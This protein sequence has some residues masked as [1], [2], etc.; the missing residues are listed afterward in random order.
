MRSADVIVVGAGPAGIAAAQAAAECGASVVLLDE[1]ARAGGQYFKRAAPSFALGPSDLSREHARGEQR[2]RAL[3]NPAITHIAEAIC[4]GIFDGGTVMVWHDGESKVFDAA[5]I[6]LATGAHDRPVPFPGWTLPGVMT[7][8][9][10]QSLAKTQWVMPG[11][12]VVL[13]G[14][15][16]FLLPVAQQ[17]IRSGAEI[18]AL[19]E[20]TSPRQWLPYLPALWGQ[21]V[22]FAE[23]WDYMRSIRRAKIPIRY[24]HKV[25]AAHGNGSVERVSIAN[26]D[27]DWRAIDGTE[28]TIDADALAVGYGFLASVELAASIGCDLRWDADCTGWF[29]R[30]DAAM[31]TSVPGVFAAGELAGFAGAAPA[32]EEGAIAGI[33]AAAHAGRAGGEADR[34]QREHTRRRARLE[35]FAS[36]VNR[37]FR[38]RPGLFENLTGDTIVCRCEEVTADEIRR[39]ATADAGSVKAI[40]DLTRAG[41][42]LCQGRFCRSSV[43]SIIADVQGVEPDS[44]SFPRVRPPVKP[45]PAGAIAQ[46]EVAEQ[47]AS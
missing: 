9:G 31:A 44:V 5:A 45:V 37:L 16:P 4:W 32:L 25:V 40:K 17:I 18:V 8:G 42:G 38:P 28:K 22:R 13:A 2:R 47:V 36:S 24:R 27:A 20:A 3:E 7:A 41:M 14:A 23:A 26:V 30:T 15:G 29:V 46:T 39:Y 35:R 11:R 34:R 43:A 19:V 10:A 6:V 1:Y 33:G 21:W 12:R